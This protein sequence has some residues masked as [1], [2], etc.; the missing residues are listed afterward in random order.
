MKSFLK[1]LKSLA[2][3]DDSI[4]VIIDDRYDVWM[5]ETKNEKQGS[6]KIS[7]NLLL[8]PPYFYH[9][10]S[11]DQNPK[12]ETY[13][14]VIWQVSRQYDLDLSLVFHLDILKRIHDKFY[15]V[16]D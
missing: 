3:G 6:K 12:I 13:K 16:Y 10:S 14:K 15:S 9:E 1:T 5:E 8:L 4:F 2:G 11:S 7:E